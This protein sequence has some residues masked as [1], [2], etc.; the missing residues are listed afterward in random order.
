MKKRS[1]A[2]AAAAVLA[3]FTALVSSSASAVATATPGSV[4]PTQQLTSTNGAVP[5]TGDFD[6]DGRDDVFWYV[7]GSG[8]DYLW[9]GKVRDDTSGTTQ[10]DRFDVTTINIFG[11]YIPIVG[12]FN[13][14][15]RDDIFW[16]GPGNTPDS[17][18]YFTGRGTVA[19]QS[20]TINGS[21]KAL[22]ADFNGTDGA[23]AE[24]I[25]WYNNQASYLWSGATGGGFTSTAIADPPNDAKVYVG[26]WRQ[27]SVTAGQTRRSVVEVSST[28]PNTRGTTANA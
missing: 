15:G 21:Y 10:A 17:V 19:G 20:M 25:F 22:V 18:W 12:D 14:D 9:S 5:V 27:K 1:F 16:Y 13:G 6:G 4:T 26:N 3:S 7:I 24:D 8:I 11:T 28:W 2:L 23:N